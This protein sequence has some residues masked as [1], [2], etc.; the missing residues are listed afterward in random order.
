MLP[1]AIEILRAI[2]QAAR[3]YRPELGQ[4]GPYRV[5]RGVSAAGLA[6]WRGEFRER[7]RAVEH[8]DSRAQR[9][10]QGSQVV[11]PFGDRHDP[12]LAAFVRGR[13]DERGQPREFRGGH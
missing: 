1:L 3:L 4:M 7:G 2:L 13:R 10:R 11:T 8:I 9:T 6:G 5:E 12:S